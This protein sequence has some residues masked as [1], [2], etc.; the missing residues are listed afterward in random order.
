MRPPADT[1]VPGPSLKT[2]TEFVESVGKL[3]AQLFQAVRSLP[4]IEAD[5]TSDCPFADELYAR[6][7]KLQ[8][9]LRSRFGTLHSY[10]EFMRS[11]ID[12]CKKNLAVLG[13]R[14]DMLHGD[15]ARARFSEAE[16]DAAAHYERCIK[17]R[18]RIEESIQFVQGVLRAASSK[19]R[20]ASQPLVRGGRTAVPPRR[21]AGS[22]GSNPELGGL[23]ELDSQSQSGGPLAKGSGASGGRRRGG[24]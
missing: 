21:S 4:R 23:F 9:E 7:E 16:A 5:G 15:R 19:Q 18:D 3:A 2:I 1:S 17:V 14:G 11:E 24:G 6:K 22:H 10:R 12:R 13:A 20:P 8:Q